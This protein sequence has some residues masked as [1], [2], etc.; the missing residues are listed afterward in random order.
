MTTSRSTTRSV[1][2]LAVAVALV[3]SAGCG[4]AAEK[5]AERAT[6]EAIENQVGGNVDLDV[7]G[8]GGV[9]IE[10]EEG[11]YEADGQGNVNIETEDGSISSSAEVPEGWP[12]D[13]PLPDDLA[14]TMGGTQDTGAGVLLTVSGTSSTEPKDLLEELKAALADWE[15]SGESVFEVDPGEVVNAQ[16]ETDGRRLTLTATS[17]GAGTTQVILSHTTLP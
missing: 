13:V 8:D 2:S 4:K 7:D 1:A 3:A 16:W 17:D 5:V 12:E 10:T 14:I 6:E 9:R 11:T 15:I